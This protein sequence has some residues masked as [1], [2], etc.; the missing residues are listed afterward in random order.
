MVNRLLE[1]VVSPMPN[2]KDS[3]PP[4]VKKNWPIALNESGEHQGNEKLPLRLFSYVAPLHGRFPLAGS[5]LRLLECSVQR[6]RAAAVPCQGER[7]GPAPIGGVL[8]T[9]RI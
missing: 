3:E 4:G 5:P 2:A 7:I 1:V 9:P 8:T 6:E